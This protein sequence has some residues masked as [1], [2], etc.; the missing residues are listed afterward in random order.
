[1]YGSSD[2]G[3]SVHNTDPKLNALMKQVGTELHW[4]EH[5]V[6]GGASQGYQSVPI[7]GAGDCEAHRGI[8]GRYYLLDLARAFPPESPIST[9]HLPPCKQSIFFRMLRP[10]LLQIVKNMN[11]NPLSCDAFSNWG[12][13]DENKVKH[14]RDVV[15]AT[16]LLVTRIV[17]E[18]VTVLEHHWADIGSVKLVQEA[19]LRGI[20]VRHLGLVR[21][22]LPTDCLV[23]RNVLLVELVSRTLKNLLRGFLR[24][25]QMQR[26]NQ[27]SPFLSKRMC[28]V[29]LNC[30]TGALTDPGARCIPAHAESPDTCSSLPSHSSTGPHPHALADSGPASLAVPQKD[31]GLA[32]GYFS[33]QCDVIPAVQER[34]GN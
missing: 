28:V 3:E 15:L 21:S 16:N 18:F 23:Q 10:E 31:S 20:N 4:A 32:L 14:C 34:Y 25:L 33:W 30:V 24:L 13:G 17:P 12:T 11:L 9:P 7:Y 22:L 5:K 6:R 29:F 19:H 2:G 1:M 8:D 27:P 26:G